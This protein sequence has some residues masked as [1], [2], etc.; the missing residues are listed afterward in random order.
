MRFSALLVGILGV[1][2][3]THLLHAEDGPWDVFSRMRRRLKP[4]VLSAIFSCFYCLSLWLAIP[5][6]LVIATFEAAGWG[7][8]LLFWPALSAGAIVV[9][10][11]MTVTDVSTVTYHEDPEAHREEP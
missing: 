6:A 3:V 9:E 7:E 5:F 8:T 2:R 11:L 4:G 10:R 1:W